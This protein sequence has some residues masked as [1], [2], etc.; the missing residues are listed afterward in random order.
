MDKLNSI[1]VFLQVARLGGFSSAAQQLGISK[2]MVSK[3]V[4]DLEDQLGVRLINRTTRHLKLTESGILYRDRVQGILEDLEATEVSVANLNAAPSGTLRLMAPTSFGSFHLARA[5]AEYRKIYPKVGIDMVF[6]GRTLDFVGEGLDLAI[7]TGELKDSTQVARRLT[8]SRLVVS[9]APEYL[10]KYGVPQVPTDLT[11]HNCLLYSPRSPLG[12][13]PFTVDGKAT[14]VRVHGDVKANTAD[15]LRIAA[16]QGCGLV[17]SPT[18]VVGLDIQAGRL[19]P[20]LE[21][22]EPPKR[23]IYAVYLHRQN[24]TAKVSTFVDFL[25]DYY[26]P[27]PYWEKWTDA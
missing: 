22:F 15:A 7:L 27:V 21:N 26:Q 14:I 20:V 10:E 13:W 25:Y 11:R 5:I 12:A 2:A 19:Q 1:R 9:A 18:Y 8:H 3:H 6:T 4:S 23:P 17:Q 24:L 16:I